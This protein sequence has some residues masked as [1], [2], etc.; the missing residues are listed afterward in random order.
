M[1]DAISGKLLFT[2]KGHRKRLVEIAYNPDGTRLATASD[3]GT[4][5]V[6]NAIDNAPS[7]LTL[8]HSPY[9]VHSISFSPDGTIVAT[10]DV[11]GTVKI[12]NAVSGEN[13]HTF[14]VFQ[15]DRALQNEVSLQR[16]A[17]SPDGQRLATAHSDGI[18]NIWGIDTWKVEMTLTGHTQGVDGVVFS[19]DGQL[20]ATA[21]W[22][23]TARL[24]DAASGQELPRPL[25]TFRAKRLRD[26]IFSPD[27]VRLATASEGTPPELGG[28]TIWDVK[29]WNITSR[30]EILSL[31]GHFDS[32]NEI[33]F[34]PDGKRLA[35]S[36]AD[37]TALIHYLDIDELM[38]LAQTRPSLRVL[39]LQECKDYLHQD[40]CPPLK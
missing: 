14:D 32:V 34:S 23:Y 11:S 26:A 9:S 3:D 16:I 21:G 36:G 22:D 38:R 27:G 28:I 13:L 17:F 5:R 19:P 15:G 1:W 39:K 2:L 6:W 12:W 33:A 29:L 20:L 10:G 35:T 30:E 31:L 40:P 25:P 24:W 7:L 8:K 18:V 37:G 4:A